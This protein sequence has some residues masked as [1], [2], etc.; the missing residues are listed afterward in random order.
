M[1]ARP[2]CFETSRLCMAAGRP[3][4]PFYEGSRPI[5]LAYFDFEN[6]AQD[7]QRDLGLMDDVFVGI[8]S[9]TC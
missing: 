7:V 4:M 9:W 6:D 5:R 3:F 2:R 8:A 1:P